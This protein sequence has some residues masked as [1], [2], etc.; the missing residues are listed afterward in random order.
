MGGMACARLTAPLLLLALPL[1]ACGA[2]QATPE[3]G[4]RAG[5][6]GEAGERAK[7][8]RSPRAQE[9]AERQA[10]R[11]ATPVAEGSWRRLPR[12]AGV[13]RSWPQNL[14]ALVAADEVIITAGRTWANEQAQDALGGVGF[15]LDGSAGRLLP[16]PASIRRPAPQTSYSAVSDGSSA[17]LWGGEDAKIGDR[18]TQGLPSGATYDPTSDRW[19]RLPPAPFGSAGHTAVWTGSEMIVWGGI[20]RSHYLKRGQR[21]EETNRGAAYAPRANSWRPIAESPL[22]PRSGASA[23][24]TGSEMIVWGGGSTE[25]HRG[26]SEVFGDGAAYDPLADSWRPITAA[27]IAGSTQPHAIWTGRRMIVWDGTEGASYSPRADRWRR[28][29][30]APLQ[31]RFGFSAVWTGEEMIVWMNWIHGRGRRPFADGAAYDPRNDAWRLLP[32]PPAEMA[33]QPAVVWTGKGLLV[34]GDRGRSKPDFSGAI[35]VP[36]GSD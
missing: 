10:V 2:Q 13:N 1:A 27:P 36:S 28:I 14:R 24:W 34:W 30:P 25:E 4:D 18:H 17:Y 20:V 11:R 16:Q 35:Y 8:E 33:Q 26:D 29:A 6:E 19:R 9:R 32:K 31:A 3:P 5:R 23:V 7:V 22:A 21:H 12:I 15:A